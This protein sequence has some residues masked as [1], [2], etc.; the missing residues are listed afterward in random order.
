MRKRFYREIARERE[1][2]R[3]RVA[4]EWLPVVDDLDRAIE[5]VSGDPQD[6][7]LSGLRVVRDHAL[8]ILARLGFPRFDDVGQRFDPTRH[9]AVSVVPSDA[10]P[11]TIVAAVRPGYGLPEVILRPAEV[12]VAGS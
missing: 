9:E 5:H 11:G 3:F 2:E 6:A 1:A 10:E 8:D 4:S 12:V 7:H